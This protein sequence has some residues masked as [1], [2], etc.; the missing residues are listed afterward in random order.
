MGKPLLDHIV[1]DS[2][3]KAE[4]KHTRGVLHPGQKKFDLYPATKLDEEKNHPGSRHEKTL[5]LL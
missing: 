5:R 2:S 4:E 1:V 3:S